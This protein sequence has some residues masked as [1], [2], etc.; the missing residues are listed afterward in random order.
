[1]TMKTNQRTPFTR[2]SRLHFNAGQDIQ[3][4][5]TIAE[6]IVRKKLA[7]ERENLSDVDEANAGGSK[8]LSSG[9]I[10]TKQIFRRPKPGNNSMNLE[11]GNPDLTEQI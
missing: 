2:N 9:Q 1:M 6:E 10:S 11:S 8:L 3:Q 7:D 5:T 4:V